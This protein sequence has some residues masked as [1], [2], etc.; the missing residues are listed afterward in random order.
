MKGAAN[1]QGLIEGDTYPKIS[2]PDH[3]AG[4]FQSVLRYKQVECLRNLVQ[5]GNLERSAGD[6]QVADD[7]R[8]LDTAVLNL[9]R[10]HD[11]VAGRNP[12]FDHAN[13]LKKWDSTLGPE[14]AAM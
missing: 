1:L 14:C 13:E 4:Q 12:S 5:L 7:A 10:F 8:Q 2:A 6:R 11:A 9:G 3:V